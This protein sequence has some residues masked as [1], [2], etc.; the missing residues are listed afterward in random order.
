M[1]L[2]WS[3]GNGAPEGGEREHDSKERGGKGRKRESTD[4]AGLENGE[5]QGWMKRRER[6]EQLPRERPVAARASKAE[7]SSTKVYHPFH[8]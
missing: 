4:I 1:R 2:I 7:V 5:K 3:I 8:P 6:E